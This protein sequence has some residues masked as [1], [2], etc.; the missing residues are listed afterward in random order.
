[1]VPALVVRKEKFDVL[2]ITNTLVT[3]PWGVEAVWAILTPKTLT[4]D[5]KIKR[6]AIC[7]FYNC[8]KHSKFKTALINHIAE[9]F[10]IIS[11]KYTTGLHFMLAAN[12]NHL[13]LEP[14]LSLR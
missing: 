1:M 9:A 2:N 13:N 5:S 3:I 14:I 6:I 11:R 12:E 8:N 10:N 4:N 7:S